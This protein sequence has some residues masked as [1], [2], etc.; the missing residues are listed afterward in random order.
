M[1]RV[2]NLS[3]ASDD[4]AVLAKDRNGNLLNKGNHWVVDPF[5]PKW[6]KM[7]RE[8]AE[9]M[10]SDYRDKPWFFGWY[11][12]NEIDY[13]ELFRYIWAEYSSKEFIKTLQ[14]K[15]QTIDTLNQR[16]SDTK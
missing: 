4:P 6:R 16:W 12:D 3:L 7:A 2:L 15:Y 13:A 14:A 11:V 1:S 5:N 9:K 10:I 8:K